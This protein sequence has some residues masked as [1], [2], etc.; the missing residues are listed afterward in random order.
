MFKKILQFMNNYIRIFLSDKIITNIQRKL[1]GADI[2]VKSEDLISATILITIIFFLIMT[3]ISTILNIPF[4]IIIMFSMGIPL[5]IS[6]Y[7]YYKN[8]KRLEKIE[9]DLPDYLRQLSALIKVGYGLESAF[10]E[11]STTI[12]NTLNDEIKRALLEISFGKPFDDA[13]MEIAIRNNSENLKHTFQIIIHSRESGGNISDV[14]ESIA[15]DLTDSIMLKKERKAGVMMSVM[16]LLISSTIATPFALGMIK[17][18]S[19]FIGQIGKT[20]PLESVIP[21]ASMGYVIIQSIL[22]SVLI[23]IVMYSDSKK[24]L[25]YILGLV[26]VSLSVYYCSQL[27]FKGILGV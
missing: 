26:P 27:L 19:E 6:T 8:E 25:K 10:N 18:Y 7:I 12:N 14:L 21:T 20:N 17:L 2:Y 4:I 9:L 16:F 15:E 11:L 13:L 22:V 24:G 3:I 1:I 5:I 23:G